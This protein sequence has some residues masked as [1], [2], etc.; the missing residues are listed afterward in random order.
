MY[1]CDQSTIT[2]LTK[3]F[4]SGMWDGRL[5][6]IA[7]V[8]Y[9]VCFYFVFI[10]FTFWPRTILFAC[11][12]LAVFID[13]N[14]IYKLLC[15][16]C[17]LCLFS[18]ETVADPNNHSFCVSISLFDPGFICLF[19]SSCIIQKWLCIK[20]SYDQSLLQIITVFFCVSY[21]LPYFSFSTTN[22][23]YFSTTFRG[24]WRLLYC[25]PFPLWELKSLLGNLSRWIK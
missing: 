10:I 19:K 18:T 1:K 13:S 4:S 14:A 3:C 5:D 11:S 2:Q 20:T 16:G 25:M 8:C 9:F 22:P 12:T 24:H 17:S 15:K 6:K 21:L 23:A 7:G